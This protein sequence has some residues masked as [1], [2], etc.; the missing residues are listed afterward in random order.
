MTHIARE[1]CGGQ[2]C[3]TPDAATFANADVTPWLEKS[4]TVN[5][6]WVAEDRR[7]LLAFGRDLLNS[8]YAGH[9]L[10]IQLFTQSPPFAQ[11]A[12]VCR[13]FDWDGP[14][15]LVGAADDLSL[16]DGGSLGGSK[17]SQRS[18]VC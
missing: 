16:S 7:K 10:T 1:L 14:V 11:L 12:A 18:T 13:D 3:I 4:Y 2:T 5:D 17:T 9:R 8:D 15:G 6:D